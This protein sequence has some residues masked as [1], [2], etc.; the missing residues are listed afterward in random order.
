MR[1]RK[2]ISIA[3][4]M[5][6]GLSL[7]S[8]ASSGGS[9]V[10][11]ADTSVAV[12][13]QAKTE[14]GTVSDAAGGDVS[15]VVQEQPQDESTA[16]QAAGEQID[17]STGTPWPYTDLDGVVTEESNA[18]IKDNFVLAVNKDS[19]L[20]TEIPEGYPFGGTLADVMKKSNDDLRDL[21]RD[22][23]PDYHDAKLAF[24]LYNR[25]M[26]WD[27]RNAVGVAPLKEMTDAMEAVDSLDDLTK[28]ITETPAEKQLA[29]LFQTSSDVDITDSSRYIIYIEDPGLLMNDS[30]QY[31]E[32]TEY[33]QIRKDAKSELA[34]KMLVKLG[35]PEEE[36]NKKI[37]NCFAFETLVAPTIPSN[38]EKGSPNY[39]ASILN[40]RTRDEVKDM[41]KQVPVLEMAEQV[42]GFPE[43]ESYI[44]TDPD[45]LAKLNEV[46]TEENLS[47]IKDYCIV[48]G[49]LN[50][51][52]LLDRECYEW[53]NECNNAMSGATGILPDET[54]M[55]DAVAEMLPWAVA[56]IYSERYLK[57]ED[58]DRVSEMVDEI[59]DRYH[60][61]IKGADFL[62]DETRVK[63]VEK[64]DAISKHIL[65]PDSWDIYSMEDLQF[66]EGGSLWDALTEM[67][68]Y[69]LDRSVREYS[70]P[71]N[72]DDWKTATP[73][74]FNCFYDPSTNGIYILGAFAQGKIYN[75]E[76]SD[77]ELYAK[78]G[79]VIGHEI[80]HAFDPKGAQF[81]KDGNFANWWT[82]EDNKVFAERTE[83]MA[84][85]FNEMHPWEGQN[86]FGQIMTGEACADMAGIKSMLLI[87]AGKENF[88]Y[89]AFF[90]AYAD[91]W[92]TKETLQR[93][94]MRIYD[95]HPMPYL[96]VN[97]T[98]QQYDEFLN[99]Y[100]IKEGDGMYL[101][102]EDR[103]AIW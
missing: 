40:Y 73:Q 91:I 103:V 64:L 87:A 45:Y 13:I 48:K 86:F 79:T 32:L 31:S 5:L 1:K 93:A 95:S 20:S 27:S 29:V 22:D 39:I 53:S 6:M 42:I 90:R 74:T 82:E 61:V 28:Y 24:E 84:A 102:P 2:L 97:A 35:Y 52:V 38:E 72:K 78:L 50:S 63:A 100:D 14:S 81:D 47:L 66:E 44:V 43:A 15:S 8:C 7:C 92:L 60:E 65:F 99:F 19:I 76:M 71:V 94:Y 98:L 89:D 88:D 96:R 17:Y 25:L 57:Q 37:E 101:A 4:A 21:F 10:Q 51:A 54:M 58:K 34:R 12:E 77:E 49:V 9:S 26:D 36:A 41:E 67:Q 59:L 16:A 23:V 11:N 46:Y 85:Y 3:I 75:S 68:V 70:E 33:G 30:A 83:K 18:D 56:R 62:S 69:K 55:S 80:S